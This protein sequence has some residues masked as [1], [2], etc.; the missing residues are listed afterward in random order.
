LADA[1]SSLIVSLLDFVS[2]AVKNEKG[3]LTFEPSTHSK[4]V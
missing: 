1:S 2:F 3:S 4:K